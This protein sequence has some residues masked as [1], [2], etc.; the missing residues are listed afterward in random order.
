MV[1]MFK[2][3]LGVWEMALAPMV[4]ELTTHRLDNRIRD[5]IIAVGDLDTPGVVE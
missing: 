5:C 2:K 3:G 4:V 1:G